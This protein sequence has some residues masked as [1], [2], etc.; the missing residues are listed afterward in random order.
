MRNTNRSRYIVLV[1][2]A[3]MAPG[4]LIEDLSDAVPRIGPVK[5]ELVPRD[6]FPDGIR[7]SGQHNPLYDALAPYS[8]FPTE[9]SGPTVWKAEEYAN[10]PERWVHRFTPEEIQ[11]LSDTADR[12]IASGTPLTGISK[13]CKDTWSCSEALAKAATT[14]TGS[15]V[16]ELPP[17]ETG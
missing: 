12:F 15:H 13:V 2:S 14:D 7:T 16:G 9:I 3:D 4:A 1:N 10:H 5:N 6:I 11:E 8:Q 17:S